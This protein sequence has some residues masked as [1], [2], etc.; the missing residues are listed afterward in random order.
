MTERNY[1]FAGLELHIEMPDGLMYESEYRLAPFSS[2]KGKNPH[3]FRFERLPR[4]PEPEG[5]CIYRQANFMVY[6][7]GERT[8]RYWGP[9]ERSWETA[10][11]RAVHDGK[12]HT[13]QLCES[14]FPSRIGARTVLDA[15]SVEH[16][17]TRNSGIVFHCSYIDIGGAAVLFTA[18]SQ[19]GKST[20]ADLWERYRGAEI[21]NGDRAAV[22]IAGGTILAEGIPYSGSS[23][24]C[25]NRSLPLKAI[26]YLG[27]AP[28]TTIRRMRGY[29]AFARIWE[30]VSV[31]TWDKKDVEL[32]SETVKT[33]AEEI[34]VYHMPCT[35][36]ESAVIA[37][38]RELNKLVTL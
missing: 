7:D 6:R 16:Y 26:V 23:P 37:L 32:A 12:D 28:V 27:Q 22:R 13:V 4:L 33:I 9:V 31:H 11:A 10:Y 3:T 38:E 18:P 17:I 1:C 36:D 30:G 35:P 8:V 14:E 2:G 15:I 5:E 34:P 24:H 19:T 29:E 20:Q 25:K 21:I